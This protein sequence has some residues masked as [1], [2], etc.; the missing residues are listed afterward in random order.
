MFPDHKI[1]IRPLDL[2]R[3]LSDLL[4]IERGAFSVARQWPQRQ[5]RCALFPERRAGWAVDVGEMLAGWLLVDALSARV[6][7]VR[8]AV[9]PAAQRHGLG[10]RLLKFLQ[11]WAR[12]CARPRLFCEAPEENL[13]IQK[14]LRAAG[15]RPT[16]LL[17]GWPP[18]GAELI[19][20]EY[21][22][23][24][25]RRPKLQVYSASHVVP[26]RPA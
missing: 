4:A 15:F 2:L 19:Q 22:A 23:R 12:D 11:G 9:H 26:R 14:L 7:I 25:A 1:D 10:V 8:V 21:P 3:D 5:W 20:F 6:R 17:H 16:A 18:A 24:P 13:A